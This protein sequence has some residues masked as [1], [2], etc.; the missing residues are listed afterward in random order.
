MK[1]QQ[2]RKGKTEKQTGR[3]A[4]QRHGQKKQNRENGK[5]EIGETGRISRKPKTVRKSEQIE[6][7][8]L[9][10]NER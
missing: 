10:K 4:K 7:E 8:W 3:K 9:M 5:K 2:C 1:K 6:K